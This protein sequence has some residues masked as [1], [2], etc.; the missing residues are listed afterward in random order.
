[1]R[2]WLL[3]L[4]VMTLGCRRGEQPP[5]IVLIVLDTTRS[6]RLSAYGYEH[7]T[8]PFLEKFAAHGVRFTQAWSVSSWTLPS[9]ATM[10]T[11]V[12]PDVHGATQENFAISED[13][14]TLAERLQKS[15]YQTA[16]FSNNPW[17]S[18]RVGLSRG[19]DHFAEMWELKG[20]RE[21]TG[22]HATLEEIERWRSDSLD[23]GKPFFAFINLIEPHLPYSPPVETGRRFFESPAAFREADAHFS[24]AGKLTVRH[25]RGE[26]P[27]TGEEWSDLG[28]LYEGELYRV[29]QVARKILSVLEG[30][31]EG[32]TVVI[33]TADHGEHHNEHSHIGHVF[34][35]YE[36]LV[37]I[38]MLASGPG[39]TPGTVREEAVS[40]LDIAPTILSIAGAS[41][42]GLDDLG[43]DL[44]GAISARTLPLTYGWPRQALRGFPVDM[45]TGPALAGYRRALRGAVHYPYK[46]IRGSDGEEV[47]YNLRNDPGENV[48][49]DVAVIPEAIRASLDATAG[50]PSGLHDESDDTEE[51]DSTTAE[52]LRLLGYIE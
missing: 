10:F 12:H 14:T 36:P 21:Q 24:E 44:R 13:L 40:L 20:E 41:T 6:D 31:R 34:S 8:T 33:I 27:L 35:L 39:F 18:H 42:R 47:Y 29:D 3:L 5:N 48:P 52:E 43:V 2:L 1:M 22:R 19:F 45:K 26:E 9:H 4:V 51:L 30:V 7:Q 49:L 23:S 17:V 37:H 16:G 50:I 46:L 28:A 11:G 15:G 32:H 25:Y 38:P